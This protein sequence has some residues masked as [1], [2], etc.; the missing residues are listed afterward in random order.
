[1]YQ[2]HKVA[3]RCLQHLPVVLSPPFSLV[4]GS[5]LAFAHCRSQSAL[6]GSPPPVLPLGQ[7]ELGESLTPRSRWESEIELRILLQPLDHAVSPIA[8][9]TTYWGVNEW[10]Q[11]C[12]PHS[13]R[14]WLHWR[15]VQTPRVEENAWLC[16]PW[17][18]TGASHPLCRGAL[19]IPALKTSWSGESRSCHGRESGGLGWD[20]PWLPLQPW[21]L[22]REQGDGNSCSKQPPSSRTFSAASSEQGSIPANG[23]Q[24]FPEDRD[25]ADPADSRRFN[26][27]GASLITVCQN[28]AAI[29]RA[30]WTAEAPCS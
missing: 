14:V 3:S 30:C 27:P 5:A 15:V 9:R 11:L 4:G 20:P 25:A 16:A 17:G 21:V 24:S 28:M 12:A 6:P 2:I 1:M 22:Q 8:A 13:L 26:L 7:R 23:P 19:G 10:L 29:Q 18:C